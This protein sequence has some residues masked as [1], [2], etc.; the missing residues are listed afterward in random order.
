MPAD[1]GGLN[2]ELSLIKTG[3]TRFASTYFMV[4]RML[5][6]RRV[7][8]R[9]LQLP[10]YGLK[11][12]AGSQ[13]GAKVKRTM[14]D[15]SLWDKAA[16]F[17]N[18]FKPLKDIIRMADHDL[19]CT[20]KIYPS[21]Q[22]LEDTWSGLESG[23]N[24]FNG[25]Q[26]HLMTKHR[27]RWNFLDFDIH[28]C[29]YALD[30]FFHDDSVVGL[31]KVMR[32]LRSIIQ[33]YLPPPGRILAMTQ[34]IAFKNKPM[35]TIMGLPPG[36]NWHNAVKMYGVKG[37][38]QIYGSEIGTELMEVAIKAHSVGS[39]VGPSERNW[40]A[41]GA[42][43]T[44]L[45]NNMSI[46]QAAKRVFVQQNMR[47]LE[48]CEMPSSPDDNRHFWGT[49]GGPSSDDEHAEDDDEPEEDEMEELN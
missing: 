16:L 29:T 17:C 3:E 32:G 2:L 46:G 6:L 43:I 4:E 7:I 21:M 44:K 33:H 49:L 39:S 5:L 1:D 40:S 11:T 26:R 13:A 18:A 24:G 22:N 25:F 10:Q 9:V 37:W 38:W 28:G 47:Q 41:F 45:R 48:R 31:Q 14:D 15:D 30:P 27:E 20:S 23:I 8:N 35:S 34:F 36:Q 42:T 12:Y 19:G